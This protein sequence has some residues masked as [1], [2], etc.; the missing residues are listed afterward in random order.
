VEVK[1]WV[2][3]A[4]REAPLYE[5]AWGWQ[6]KIVFPFVFS[7]EKK[8]RPN[9][10]YGKL[11]N[12]QKGRIELFTRFAFKRCAL[13]AVGENRNDRHS[14]KI[15]RALFFFGPLSV[16]VAVAAEPVQTVFVN[17]NI[18][19]MNE[20]QPRAEAIAVKGERIVFVGS[21]ADA[22]KYQD[23]EAKTV[24]LAGKTV[25]PGLTDSHCHIFG[26]GE[27]EMTLNLEGTNTLEDFLAKVK[28]RVAKTERGKWVT[29]RGWIETFWKPPQFPTRADLDKIAPDNPVL[30]T[31][32]D[33][34][35]A[36]ANSAALNLAKIDKQ[37]PNPFGGEIMRD[38]QSG[39]A[40]GMLLDHAQ[41]LVRKNI[42]AP[43][44]AER[45]EA[46]V[47]G[48][49]RE[50]S[51]GWCE[52]QNAGSNP[53]DVPPM[54]QAF[55][56]GQCKLRVYNAIYGPGPG[57]AALL[58]DGAVLN[59]FDDHFTER[60]IKVVFDGALGSRGAALLKPYADAPDTS[61]YLTQK[62]TELQPMFE[63]ALRQGVQVETH[64]IGDRANRVI[65]DLY[66]KAMKAVP[67]EKRK[68]KEPRWRVEH[69]QILSAQDLP[70][71]ARFGVIAS[72]QPSHAISDLFFAPSRLGN[73]RLAGAYAWQTLLKSG[74]TICGG[75]DAPVERGEPMIEFYAAVA[76]KSIRGESLDGWH[77]EQA[78]SREQALKMFTIAP[79]Y[80]AFEEKDKGSIENGKL[81]DL[82]IL[83]KDIMKIPEPEILKTT[84]AMAVIGGEIV[85]EAR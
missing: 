68:I 39:E 82:T 24:D 63:E 77:P 81:A 26:I 19:T 64:A 76:R 38:K 10:S 21:N 50:L 49:K 54:V 29:G 41:E 35:A 3:A 7:S 30:L 4:R 57:A 72:M 71:F 8:R 73:E 31:R 69:A 32:A 80:A 9:S 6:K 43:T 45:R 25:V 42:P 12:K 78:V 70:R 83:T 61:G 40:T 17:G 66:E 13:D 36:I 11:S 34:H 51:L 1:V 56:A 67:P 59:M 60:T 53:D 2:A 65:L 84:C 5:P 27:R 20:T 58:H 79:A 33:G 23:G 15:F 48:V 52:I 44:E 62:E 14:M 18:Y 75:S 28:E 37:T 46:F 22:K 74:A 16:A 47:V 85:Y 55:E